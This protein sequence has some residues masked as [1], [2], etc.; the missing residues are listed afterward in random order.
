MV[1]K[2]SHILFLGILLA[3]SQNALGI[4]FGFRVSG[5][6][7][8]PLSLLFHQVAVPIIRN[9]VYSVNVNKKPPRQ[10]S[11]FYQTTMQQLQEENQRLKAQVQQQEQTIAHL[12]RSYT[13]ASRRHH[14][15]QTDMQRL[16]TQLQNIQGAYKQEKMR[17][18]S[19]EQLLQSFAE[20]KKL[21]EHDAQIERNFLLDQISQL[22]KDD[23]KSNIKCDCARDKQLVADMN[24][25][26]IRL[27]EEIKRVESENKQLKQ[28]FEVAYQQQT[29]P[30]LPPRNKPKSEHVSKPLHYSEPAREPNQSQEQNVG[31]LASIRN[32]QISDL[33]K[34]EKVKSRYDKDVHTIF[35]SLEKNITHR[36][37]TGVSL[38]TS[39]EVKDMHEKYGF[40]SV[41]SLLRVKLNLG[42]E[43]SSL[44][45]SLKGSASDKEILSVIGRTR[46]KIALIDVII[47]QKE[48]DEY[49]ENDW[50]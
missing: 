44:K 20:E 33:R 13:E 1:R 12:S 5:N 3:I 18:Q 30:P 36:L 29:P 45:G 43:I 39:E 42:A 49:E 15:H 21:I 10:Q 28:H 24:Q 50:D 37:N 38:L 22:T 14:E 4:Q 32:A 2:Y 27:Q 46:E 6:I 35:S 11:A 26:M 25:E 16:R 7:R 48:S 34:V 8:Q 41:E 31:L 9:I 19:A 17:A 23:S 40:Q 47:E